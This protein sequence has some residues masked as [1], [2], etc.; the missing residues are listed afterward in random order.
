MPAGHPLLPGKLPGSTY[1]WQFYLRR[2]LT[3]TEFLGHVCA[4]FWR[5]FR[6]DFE[7][8]PFQ[9][10]G[11]ETGATP[12]VIAL[13]L[14]APFPVNCFLTRAERKAYGLR[15][16]FEG[17]VDHSLPV[18]MVDDM[19]HSKTTMARCQKYL[20]QEGLQ[21]CEQAFVIVDKDV[22]GH[23]YGPLPT[24]VYLFKASQF[25]LTYED[26]CAHAGVPPPAWR[27]ERSG[28]AVGLSVG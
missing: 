16:R 11:L 27:F 26:Y 13:A 14:T 5:L 22:S 7:K 19:S 2:G 10:T 15:N 8:Q 28:D 3:N 17:I 21:L 1:R 23:T 25:H 9:L 20:L 18:M 4:F 24:V 6:R 12:L